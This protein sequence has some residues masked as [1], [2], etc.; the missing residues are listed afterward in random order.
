VCVCVC[1]CVCTYMYV[2]ILYEEVPVVIA[3]VHVVGVRLCF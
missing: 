3:A 2:C 1:V